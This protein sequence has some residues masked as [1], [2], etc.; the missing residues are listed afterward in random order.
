M[1]AESRKWAVW[2]A[3]IS[4]SSLFV[5]TVQPLVLGWL[6]DTVNDRRMQVVLVAIGVLVSLALFQ[7]G[8]SLAGHLAREWLWNRNMS[9]RHNRVNELFYEKSLGQ[10]FEEGS[11]LN[12]ASLEKAN[13]RVMSMQEMLLFETVQV[14]LSVLFS[15]ML[16]WYLSWQAGLALSALIVFHVLWSLRLNYRVATGTADIE[17]DFRA[18][19]RQ[20]VERWEKIARVKT[21]GKSNAEQARLAGWYADILERDKR[22]WF[23]FNYQNLY[24]D[25]IGNVVRFSIVGYGVYLVYAGESQV[26]FLLPLY[27]WSTQVVQN[28]WFF[29]HTERRIGESI[30]YIRAMRTALTEPPAFDEAAG[31]VLNT[32]HPVGV[33]FKHVNLH[34]GKD[35]AGVH[36]LR[37]V[38]F[39]IAPGEKVALIGPSGAGKSSIMKLLL[40]FMDPTSGEIWINGHQLPQLSL[41]SWMEHVGY[42]PQD[43]QVFDGTLRYNLTYGLSSDRQATITDEEIW[44]VMRLLKIDFGPRLT[45]GLDTVV[46]RDG[47]KLSGGER[48][49]L[50]AGAAVIK[51]PIF[52]VIDEAT[53]SLD[54][55]TEKAVQEGLSQVL[56][57]PAGAL[58]VAHRLSTVRTICDRFMVL[59]KLEDT[60]PGESQIEAVA[61]SFEELY[62]ISQTFRQL[63][64]DQEIRI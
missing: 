48:Q 6:I 24:R 22:F 62:R 41:I 56:S 23:W 32:D 10:H 14:T 45:H 5:F 16:M 36:T 46:G 38:N 39:S 15:F 43:S 12:Y 13:A 57:G 30:P 8:A 27:T 18:E 25:L 59:R 34:Y 3:L 2:Y 4:G 58:I 9:R 11:H 7:Q 55:T 19:N 53:S 52:M 49:R 54:S 33:R 1:S 26:G 60:P 51:K 42:I 63:A 21:S 64:D 20:L 35:D 47:V 37:D 17:Q 40:R 61:D 28:L 29:G 31:A 50:I 44:E